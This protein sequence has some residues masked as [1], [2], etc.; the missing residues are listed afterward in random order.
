V[1]DGVYL[2]SGLNQIEARRVVEAVM[3]HARRC[4]DQSLGVGSF[5]LHQQLAIQDD[6]ER[7]R[8]EARSHLSARLSLGI[9]AGPSEAIDED[10]AA[11][12]AAQNGKPRLKV[13]TQHD[14]LAS[15]VVIWISDGRFWWHSLAPEHPTFVGRTAN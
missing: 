7:H 13:S 15:R 5:N 11:V 12:T 10:D 2:G 6:L 9:L 4:S 8:R 3:E 14:V 1:P